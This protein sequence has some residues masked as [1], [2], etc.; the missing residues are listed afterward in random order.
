MNTLHILDRRGDTA[1]TWTPTSR[2]RVDAA[3]K[4]FD[5]FR[6]KNYLA[7]AAE[8]AVSGEVIREFDPGASSI[9]MHRPL[10]AG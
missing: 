7:F 5:E 4:V 10:V 1:V 9:I 6:A 3:R 2:R 8:G